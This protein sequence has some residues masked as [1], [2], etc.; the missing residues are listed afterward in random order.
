MKWDELYY[1]KKEQLLDQ[2]AWRK[3]EAPQAS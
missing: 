2:I 3:E 1:P